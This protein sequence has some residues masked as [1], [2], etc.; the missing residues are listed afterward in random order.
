[1]DD[2]RHGTQH[3]WDENHCENSECTFPRGHPGMCSH[4]LVGNDA[5]GQ[6]ANRLRRRTHQAHFIDS[7]TLPSSDDDDRLD[8]VFDVCFTG[9]SDSSNDSSNKRIFSVHLAESKGIPIPRT[10]EE[11]MAS[12]Y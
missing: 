9:D 6:P 10:Y 7:T 3:D 2:P 4:Q 12:K 5:V 8:G 11:A 1:M